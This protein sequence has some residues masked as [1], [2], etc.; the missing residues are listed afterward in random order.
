MHTYSPAR[1]QFTPAHCD[2]RFNRLGYGAMQLAGPHVWGPPKDRAAAV[3]VLREAIELG[4]NHIDTSDFYG[5]HV[6]NQI[7]REALHPYRDG[8]T[9]VTKIGFVRGADQSWLPA[10]SPQQLRDA[11]HD[12]LRN[13]GLDVLDVV[14]LRAPG[15]DGADGSSLAGPLDTLV[16]LQREGLVRH[17]GL[18]NVDAAQV[19]KAQRISPIVCVQNHYNLAHRA[20]DALIDSLAAQG[21]A[22]VPF[23]P[24]G[25]FSPLQS[26]TLNQVA[27]A[28]QATPMQV[29]LAWLL[30]RAPNMLVIPGTSSVAHLRENVAA[31]ALTLDA[32]A[33]EA[34]RSLATK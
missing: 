30:Q 24:L 3:A 2:I 25:G 14:N 21:I 32:Q 29:A 11:V 13:L 15:M 12:N 20:D 16:Q 9:I 22:Y 33:L 5:P 4:V 6:T 1:D 23:F 34:L 17:I 31:G 7:I 18:S 26:D 8:L 10:A 19:A 27:A 28:L